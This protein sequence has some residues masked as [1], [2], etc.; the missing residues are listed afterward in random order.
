MKILPN[1]S[2]DIYLKGPAYFFNF[3]KLFGIWK[4]EN[5]KKFEFAAKNVNFKSRTTPLS[6]NLPP[7]TPQPDTF[8]P[9]TPRGKTSPP[10]V[11]NPITPQTWGGRIPETHQPRVKNPSTLGWW[12]SGILYTKV[13]LE[14]GFFILGLWCSPTSR[15]WSSAVLYIFYTTKDQ[16]WRFSCNFDN[17]EWR[18]PEPHDS[19]I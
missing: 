11:K 13:R 1:L 9:T 4:I 19:G 16:K 3:W 17:L 14:I 8:H 18:T 10:R 12:G 5:T 6:R 2:L 7:S 15:W